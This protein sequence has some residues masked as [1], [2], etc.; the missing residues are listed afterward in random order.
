[1]KNFKLKR[2]W[3]EDQ[4]HGGGIITIVS[5]DKIHHLTV[6]LKIKPGEKLRLFNETD[7]EW[8]GEV[9][10]QNHKAIIIQIEE[11]L[12]KTKPVSNVTIA[13]APIK[14]D[15]MRFLIEKATEI[16]AS[17]FIPVITERTVVR[18]IHGGKLHAY[19][20]SAAEQSERLS[21][22]TIKEPV[23][24]K[25]FIQLCDYPILFCSERSDSPF[26][27][28]SV[29]QLLTSSKLII[30]IGPEGGFTEGEQAYLMSK[31][32]IHPVSL[33]SNILRA[34]TAAIFGL[35]CLIFALQN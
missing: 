27:S 28:R 34:E 13:F 1:M 14:P 8:L 17:E 15:A 5:K 23:P 35:S 25:N 19:A 3:V 26:I 4:L 7:G 12:L 10:A 6:V 32:N 9:Q 2:V 20:L 31:K 29:Q 24:L 21:V 18:H 30:L 16:G 11:Q 22:P 33:G